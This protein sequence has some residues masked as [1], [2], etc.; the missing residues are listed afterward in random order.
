M[1]LIGEPCEAGLNFVIIMLEAGLVESC[2]V[3][4]G[5]CTG[6]ARVMRRQLVE[7]LQEHVLRG[8]LIME[9]HAALRGVVRPPTFELV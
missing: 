6:D 1:E 2:S 5:P 9:R 8:M 4:T 7:L 3:L